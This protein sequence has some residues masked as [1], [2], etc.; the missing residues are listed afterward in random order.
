MSVSYTNQEYDIVIQHL[1]FHFSRN[2]LSSSRLREVKNKGKFQ[3]FIVK[4]V[5]VPYEW[6]DLDTFGMLEKDRHP[7]QIYKMDSFGLQTE[8]R[9]GK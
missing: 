9:V 4:S 3:T 7:M 1:I 6:I 8:N 5:A 2:Y